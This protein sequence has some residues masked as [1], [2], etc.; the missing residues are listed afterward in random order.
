MQKANSQ[1]V[2]ISDKGIDAIKNNPKICDLVFDATTA[3]SH[4]LH[5]PVFKELGIKAIDMTPSQ[6]GKICVPAING[7]GSISENNI[8]MITCG[9]QASTPLAYVLMKTIPG[10][11]YIETVS[12]IASRSAGPGTRA[13]I[14]EYIENTEMGIREL[15]GCKNVKAILNLN[16]AT[17]CIDMQ[18]TVFAKV[19]E[20]DTKLLEGPIF[21]ME[22]NIQKYVPGYKIVVPPVFENGR[23]MVMVRVQ[24]LGDYLPKYAGN[25]DIINCAAIAM[26]EEYAKNKTSLG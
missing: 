12:S 23:I 19:K 17:P 11:E 14:D 3:S 13:N 10:I 7:S 9:G 6:I 1:G 22:R 21:A 4:K 15:T 26:A 16:P 2:H 5:A 24:G 18:T 8:N 25:L 20:C